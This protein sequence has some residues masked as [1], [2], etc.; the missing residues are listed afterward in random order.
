MRE[1]GELGDAHEGFLLALRSVFENVRASEAEHTVWR[2]RRNTQVAMLLRALEIFGGPDCCPVCKSP[3]KWKAG[4]IPKDK[5]RQDLHDDRCLLDIMI[6][7]FE[8]CLE[9]PGLW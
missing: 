2:T 7:H 1:L 5:E 4:K 6:R 9:S 8:H 3:P